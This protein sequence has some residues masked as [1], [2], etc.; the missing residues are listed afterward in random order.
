MEKL[1]CKSCGANLEIDDK[2][3]F[4][5]C[6]YCKTQYKLKKDENSKLEIDENAKRIGKV[7][8]KFGLAQYI[9][10]FVLAFAI[11]GV[12]IFVIFRMYDG[13]K[14]M[15]DK[16]GGNDNSSIKSDYENS[17]YEMYSGESNG[18]L[19]KSL[20]DKVITNNKKNT[21]MNVTITNK[22]KILK[23]SDEIRTFS[24]TVENDQKYIIDLDYN[25]KGNVSNINVDLK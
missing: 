5:V 21:S 15:I 13:G 4:A 7:I 17:V 10:I 8:L 23:T 24:N 6:P 11:I 22:E 16:I 19:L 20:L 1:K 18:F 3:E 2:Q 25:E 14:E 12:T 9:I